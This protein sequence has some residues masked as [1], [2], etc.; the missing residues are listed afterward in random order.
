[1]VLF[2]HCTITAQEKIDIIN[3]FFNKA[4]TALEKSDP[5]SAEYYFE[6]ILE[7][8][9]N[10][11]PAIAGLGKIAYAEKDWGNVLDY[12]EDI[13][14]I[15]TNNIEGILLHGHRLQGAG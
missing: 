3:H 6:E 12:F 1:M 13:A 10:N 4:N 11:L 7:I 2:S 9:E 8:D 15:D 14:E 5:D